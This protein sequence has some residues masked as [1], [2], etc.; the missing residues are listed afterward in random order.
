[1]EQYLKIK[2][3]FCGKI[4]TIKNQEGL[5]KCV[6]VCPACNKKSQVASCQRVIFRNDDETDL[7][8]RNKNE[9]SFNHNCVED[10]KITGCIVEKSGKRWH[11]HV[12]VNT[13]GRKPLDPTLQ[14]DIPIEDYTGQKK[15]SRH[16]AKI[17]VQILPDGNCK[18]ILYN[19]E[20][21]NSTFVGNEKIDNNDRIV[22]NN[23]M[24]L[25]FGDLEIKFVVEKTDYDE[26]ITG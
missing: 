16:H 2:C 4:L 18:H 8:S 5:E 6:V 9:E 24:N 13:I 7:N 19:W 25:K 23:G 26:T 14:P 20:N 17:E 21:K 12:G 22:L 15:M 1:M 3:P 10:N 11:L